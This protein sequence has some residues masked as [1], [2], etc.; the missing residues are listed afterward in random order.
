M[1][2]TKLLGAGPATIPSLGFGTFRM[3]GAD[4]LQIVPKAL[5]IGY[6]HIDTA[7]IYGNEAEV[8]EA[9]EGSKLPRNAIFLT[10][11][12]WV[13]H[14]R[15]GD[16]QQSVATS[17]KKLRTDHVNLLLLHWPNPKVPFAETLDALNAVQRAGMAQHI[18]VSNLN[19][20]QMAEAVRLSAAPLVTNQV[21][22]HPYLN[23]DKLLQAARAANMTVT[24]YYGLADGTVVGD[25]LL[26]TIGER[27]GK[28]AVQVTLRW[29]VQQPGVVAL[30]KTVQA[31]RA[32]SNFEIF[33]FELSA[34]DMAAI[35]ALTTRHKRFVSPDGLAPTWDTV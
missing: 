19:T 7:Q 14:Y 31:A 20:T 1:T 30:T 6:R 33:D 16:L 8:G 12:V 29:L 24:A 11:K 3:P 21:E 2:T 5:D 10:T 26:R 13:D 23:Q 22:Y 28:S 34:E 35:H 32:L 25:P 15:A 17:L 27:H 9:I 18:G 4:V